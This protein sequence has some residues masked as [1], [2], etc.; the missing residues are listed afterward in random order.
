MMWREI[1]IRLRHRDKL[2]L[3]VEINSIVYDYIIILFAYLLL[4]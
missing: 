3:V 2:E 1:R 4:I